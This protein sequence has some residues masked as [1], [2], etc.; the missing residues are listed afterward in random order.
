V[1][2]VRANPAV[3]VQLRGDVFAALARIASVAERAAVWERLTTE[4]PKY[5]DYQKRSRRECPV[6][7]IEPA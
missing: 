7:I 4:I 5:A 6:V 1:R 2:N 3:V